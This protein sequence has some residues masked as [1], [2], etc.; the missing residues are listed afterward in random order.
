MVAFRQHALRPGQREHGQHHLFQLTQQLILAH[1]HI[2]RG[3]H[4]RDG[5]DKPAANGHAIAHHLGQ[6]GADKACGACK[7]LL[8]RAN[9]VFHSVQAKICLLDGTVQV[10]HIARHAVNQYHQAVHHLR[11]HHANE[12]R[13]HKHRQH[14]G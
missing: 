13:N 3:N 1:Q 8:I 10:F 6:H 2:N 4:R 7:Q 12:K 9:Q 11:H 5:A 14:A